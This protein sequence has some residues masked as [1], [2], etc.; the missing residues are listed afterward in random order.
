MIEKDYQNI[1][2][3]AIR[4]LPSE[5]KRPSIKKMEGLEQDKRSGWN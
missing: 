3:N 2:K 4:G 1:P 5:Y